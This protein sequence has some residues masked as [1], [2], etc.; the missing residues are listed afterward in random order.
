MDAFDSALVVETDSRKDLRL[1]HT[2]KIVLTGCVAAVQSTPFPKFLY[3]YDGGFRV[4]QLS[5]FREL[6]R[7]EYKGDAEDMVVIG[8]RMAVV[9]KDSVAVFSRRESRLIAG[10]FRGCRLSNIEGRL[11]VQ[12]RDRL[13]IYSLDTL[14]VEEEHRCNTHCS[15]RDVL[16]TCYDCEISLHRDGAK[17]LEIFMPETIHRICTDP[18]L[19]NIYCAGTD[20]KIFCCSMNGGDP[21]TMTYHKALVMDIGLSFCG[22]YLYS[23]DTE[24]HVCIWDTAFNTVVGKIALESPVRRMHVV[25]VS[26]GDCSESEA[27]VP[28]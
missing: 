2:S 21:A 16:V 9:S 8:D 11:G 13:V 10:S 17:I 7:F 1:P 12:G 28:C 22:R 27:V 5:P 19:T 24:G 15:I 25:Y 23:A 4:H 20:G 26:E 3:T 14:E 6:Q 18:L